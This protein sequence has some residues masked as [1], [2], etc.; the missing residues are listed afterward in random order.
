MN[1][2]E[3]IAVSFTLLSVILTIKK[4][5]WCWP[6]GI[7]GIIVYF[8]LM[9]HVKLYADAGLQAFFF[10]QSVYGWYLWSNRKQ[11][12]EFK[13]T[14]LSMYNTIIVILILA[15]GTLVCGYILHMYTNASITFIDSFLSIG[16]II[17]TQL[18][19]KKK[20]ESW[21]LWMILDIIYVGVFFYK[22]LT[23]SSLLYAIFFILAIQGYKSWMKS[24]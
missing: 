5:I 2:I 6:V 22:D 16:S 19:T 9:V 3:I 14:R 20:L 1:I 21:I 15:L 12:N 18:L 13:V 4:S 23:L 7:I 11:K 8:Y 24:M 10:I 17:A